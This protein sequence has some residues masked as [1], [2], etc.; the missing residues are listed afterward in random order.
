M[1]LKRNKILLILISFLAII[2]LLYQV[3][4]I[5]AL[6]QNEVIGVIKMDNAV[7]KISINGLEVSSGIVENLVID[8]IIVENNENVKEGKIAPGV[9]GS[10]QIEINP[11]NTQVSVRYDVKLESTEMENSKIEISDIEEGLV[12]NE[13]IKTGEN[14]YTGIIPLY[15]IRQGVKNEIKVYVNWTNDEQNNE[16]DT[17]DG[18]CNKLQNTYSY[19]YNNKSISRRR[20]CTI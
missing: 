2:V 5:Y 16:V 6:F 14:T 8:Q 11:N 4:T 20:D 19:Y 3:I 7:W 10:F 17:R 12:N 15:Q 13:L 9:R 18:N 1:K